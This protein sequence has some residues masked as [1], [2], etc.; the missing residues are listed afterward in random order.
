[1]EESG[2]RLNRDRLANAHRLTRSLARRPTPPTA[3]QSQIPRRAG[4][5]QAAVIAALARAERSLRALEVHVAAEELAAAGLSWNTVKDCL[6][7]NARRPTSPIE[8]IRHG[9]YRH[10]QEREPAESVERLREPPGASRR[11]A[12]SRRLATDRLGSNGA[13]RS[14]VRT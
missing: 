10:R 3:L 8:R 7:K 11:L 5:V 2:P 14:R 1:M 4:A 12:P 9:L 13:S 6:H